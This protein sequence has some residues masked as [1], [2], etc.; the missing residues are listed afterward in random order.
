MKDR[1]L[2]QERRR[3]AELML[4]IDKQLLMCDN[5]DDMLMLACAMLQR[6]GEI[7]D[8]VLGDKGRHMLLTDAANR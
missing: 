6:T 2:E 4:P 1:D 5:E 7:F 3:M 8:K